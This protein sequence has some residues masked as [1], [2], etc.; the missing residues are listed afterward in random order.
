MSEDSWKSTSEVQSGKSSSSE[1]ND[2]AE[3]EVSSQVS[4][5]FMGFYCFSSRN[6]CF[7]MHLYFLFP[8]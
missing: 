8:L 1:I 3:Q 5:Y 7:I 4:S 6:Q 2:E